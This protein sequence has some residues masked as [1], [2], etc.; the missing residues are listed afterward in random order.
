LLVF[1]KTG[2]KHHLAR[3]VGKNFSAEAP[4]QQVIGLKAKSYFN[5]TVKL[6]AKTENTL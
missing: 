3:T 6:L 1:N 2:Q 4:L 5:A